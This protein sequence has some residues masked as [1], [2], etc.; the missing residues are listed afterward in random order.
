MYSNEMIVVE[1]KG[2]SSTVSDRVYNN[3][4]R[5]RIALVTVLSRQPTRRAGKR[6]FLLSTRPNVAH[7]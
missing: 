5:V 7:H 6:W 3:V 1:M 4:L 2:D